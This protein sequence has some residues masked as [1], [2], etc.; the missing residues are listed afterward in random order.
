MFVLL[1]FKLLNNMDVFV[2]PHLR[3]WVIP[4]LCIVPVKYPEKCCTHMH[5][6]IS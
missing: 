3:A 5:R 4:H 6:A 2:I 1:Y